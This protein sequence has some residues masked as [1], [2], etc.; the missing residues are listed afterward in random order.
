MIAIMRFHSQSFSFRHSSTTPRGLVTCQLLW[1]HLR[2]ICRHGL[3]VALQ[4]ESAGLRRNI[5]GYCLPH[6]LAHN[7]FTRLGGD[8]PR[9]YGFTAS[10]ETL[11]T[12]NFLVA[13]WALSE[14]N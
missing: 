2:G 13:P 8:E 4:L 6:R 1:L 10:K 12:P 14:M 11:F 3:V 9:A 7:K 5:P